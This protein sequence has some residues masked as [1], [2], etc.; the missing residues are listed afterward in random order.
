MS[1]ENEND[2]HHFPGPIESGEIDFCPP[3]PEPGQEIFSDF[4]DLESDAFSNE[5]LNSIVLP[6]FILTPT[7]GVAEQSSLLLNYKAVH[8]P[9]VFKMVLR[10]SKLGVNDFTI[11]FLDEETEEVISKWRFSGVRVHAIDF[12]YVT[13][14]RTEEGSVSVEL[15]Y[16]RMTI[17]DFDF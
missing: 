14:K 11:K 6:K 10:A 17:D 16:E 7:K 1:N 15:S 13:N 3:E 4:F 2:K 5:N 9:S 12:G 8:N